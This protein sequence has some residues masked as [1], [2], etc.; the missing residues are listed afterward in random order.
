MP[1]LLKAVV[2]MQAGINL[3]MHF[4]FQL[5]NSNTINCLIPNS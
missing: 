2:S 1:D 5:N 3:Q 4:S